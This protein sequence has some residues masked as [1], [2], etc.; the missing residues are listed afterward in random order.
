M[1]WELRTLRQIDNRS[2]F[3]AGDSMEQGAA[4]TWVLL[5]G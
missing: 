4:V 1:S 3:V 2:W 5:G